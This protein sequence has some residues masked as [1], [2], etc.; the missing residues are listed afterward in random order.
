MVNTPSNLPGDNRGEHPID[1]VPPTT[2]PVAFDIH[3][4]A[5]GDD[6][7]FWKPDLT[8]IAKHLGW[9]W[10]LFLPTVLLLGSIAASVY[11]LHTLTP[12]LVGGGK[13]M[14]LCVGIAVSAAGTAIK[15]AT[16]S[17][18][19][20]FC[21]HCG[22]SLVGLSEDRV[23]PECGRPFSYALIDEYRRD[24]HWFVQRYKARKAPEIADTAFQAGSVRRKKSRDGT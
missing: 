1:I 13:L 12:L 16:K 15:S 20:P 2:R 14:I 5:Y 9:R 18:K 23:C 3:H 22:Y 8:D 19:E 17:R 10:V 6:V 24:P 4:P 11:F 7:P 21:I